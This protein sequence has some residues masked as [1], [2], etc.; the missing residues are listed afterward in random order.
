MKFVW[1]LS[2][3]IADGNLVAFFERPVAAVLGV[4]AIFI[5]LYPLA[6]GLFLQVWRRTALGGA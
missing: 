4:I 5:W 2:Q 1:V 6:E 3:M